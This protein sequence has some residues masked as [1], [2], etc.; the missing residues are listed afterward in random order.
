MTLKAD[1]D[2][3]EP[4]TK[5]PRRQL[6]P[7]PFLAEIEQ[8]RR[9]AMKAEVR[10]D[11]IAAGSALV[12]PPTSR[13]PLLCKIFAQVRED[14]GDHFMSKDQVLIRAKKRHA[15]ACVQANRVGE[16]LALFEKLCE[17]AP[18]DAEFWFM[19]G[20]L[21]GRLGRVL[22][23]ETA[24]RKAVKLRPGVTQAYLNL[25]HALELQAKFAEAEECYRHALTLK[26]DLIE[27]HDA[28]GRLDQL[29]GDL[30]A[31]LAHHQQAIQLNP[32]RGSA[33]LSL[34]RVLQ[35]LGDL[36]EAAAALEQALERDPDLTEANY[37]LAVVRKD[38]GHY[39]EARALLESLLAKDDLATERRAQIH[40]RLGELHDRHG[41]F[42]V[43]FTQFE[44]GQRLVPAQFDAREWQ[45]R[46][47]E[48]MQTFNHE[49]MLRAPRA[50]NCSERPLFIVGMPH[51]GGALVEQILAMHPDM[52]TAGDVLDMGRLAMEFQEALARTMPRN[53]ITQL[54][55]EQCDGWAQPYLELMEQRLPGSKRAI[56]ALP[57]NF[58][59]LGI[60]ALLFPMARMIHCVRDPLDTC[61][62]AYL[63]ESGDDQPYA[64][65]LADL[66]AYYR[67]YQGLMIHWGQVLDIPIFEVRYEELL[68]DPK[69]LT[70]A[71]VEFCGFKWDK[72]CL[73]LYKGKQLS[74]IASLRQP[75]QFKQR[76]A[77]GWW[78]NYADYLEPLKLA[79]AGRRRS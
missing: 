28:L 46:I 34:G 47:S 63:H 79:L 41:E 53:A 69:K 40:F 44:A 33:Y 13:K 73:A 68:C 59:Y 78:R 75:S 39:D 21:Y 36:D 4:L 50:G 27:A 30:R 5:S 25:G 31:A 45:A 20:T 62:S 67:Q 76:S 2:H 61:L 48:T 37:E 22:E 16:A 6:I 3:L 71:M 60:I 72:R 15:F 49:A 24:L 29:R 7:A 10:R 17:L 57:Q 8:L 35:Q 19:V 1:A 12:N 38:Q 70:R 55:R 14:S 9:C 52:A 51:A 43:A 26:A 77:V 54:S 65:A 23:A 42:A 74:A 56:D 66:G 18:Q 11:G 32:S 64:H 58:L